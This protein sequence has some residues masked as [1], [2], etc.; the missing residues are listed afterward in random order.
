M[1]ESSVER[2][3]STYFQSYLDKTSRSLRLVLRSGVLARIERRLMILP[4]IM[5]PDVHRPFSY[6][7]IVM[8]KDLAASRA[9]IFRMKCPEVA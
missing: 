1:A 3:P 8:L 2:L 7:A 5:A 6:R 4:G 9:L